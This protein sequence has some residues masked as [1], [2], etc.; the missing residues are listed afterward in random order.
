M[1]QMGWVILRVNLSLFISTNTDVCYKFTEKLSYG[2]LKS[3]VC[4]KEHR[5]LERGCRS[6][7][8]N[9]MRFFSVSSFGITGVS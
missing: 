6:I 5:I 8:N 7:V 4:S 1:S 2:F 3:Q 9:K